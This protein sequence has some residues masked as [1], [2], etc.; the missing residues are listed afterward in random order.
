V[1][2]YCTLKKLIVSLLAIAGMF[3]CH[4]QDSVAARRRAVQPSADFDQRFYY[5]GAEKQNIWGY[6]LG[7]QVHEKYK[8]GLGAYYMNKT[9]GLADH[10]SLTANSTGLV[11]MQRQLYLGTVYYE[12]YLLRRRLW[13]ASVVVE[14]GYGALVNRMVDIADSSKHSVHKTAMVPAGAGVSISFK[15]PAVHNMYFL[16][17]IGINLMGGYRTAVWQQ[18]K[19]YSFNGFYW[20]LSGAVFLDK[21][22]EDVRAGRKNKRQKQATAELSW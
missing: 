2:P 13:E 3:A 22:L 8:V 14:A 5:T 15:P 4:A 7:V 12:P 21:I 16:Q 11:A 10:T 6:R 1:R 20:S 9:T 19:Q 17:W 18:D